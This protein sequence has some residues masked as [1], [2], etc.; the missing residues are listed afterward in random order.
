[1][2][3]NFITL[4]LI[5]KKFIKW[6]CFF[7]NKMILCNE[8]KEIKKVSF[9]Q[10]FVMNTVLDGYKTVSRNCE[11][12]GSAPTFVFGNG[13]KYVCSVREYPMSSMRFIKH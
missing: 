7:M 1:M 13:I 11:S 4:S 3:W 5:F 12:V 9:F 10:T 2:S 6:Q 8:I